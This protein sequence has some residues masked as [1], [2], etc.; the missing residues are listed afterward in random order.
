M[1]RGRR[2]DWRRAEADRER[3]R[4]REIEH[5]RT[6]LDRSLAEVDRRR[7]ELTDLKLQVRRHPRVVA[8]TGV[9]VLGLLGGVGFAI[10]R[11]VKKREELPQKASSST[12]RG[13]NA[14]SEKNSPR[15][16][17]S[18]RSFSKKK[19]VLPALRALRG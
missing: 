15:S 12:A 19:V 10:W 16:A 14:S 17:R 2:N 18:A 11:A 3:E 5:L 7:H 13:T 8:G 4:E 1:Q 9:V 6:R